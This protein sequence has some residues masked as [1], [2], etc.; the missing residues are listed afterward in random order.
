MK[1]EYK[2]VYKNSLIELL[3]RELNLD[4]LDKAVEES[5]CLFAPSTTFEKYGYMKVSKYIYCLNSLYLDD[6]NKKEETREEFIKNT[7][8]KVFTKEGVKNITYFEPTPE[9]IIKNGTLVFAFVYG[10]NKEEQSKEEYI[11]NIRKQKEVINNI[12]EKLEKE[13]LEK[14]NI[15]CKMLSCKIL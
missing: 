15:E 4:N 8:K 2:E 6:L 13:T 5:N 1:E 11:N 10:K 9:T 12:K 14:L 7:L 3:K